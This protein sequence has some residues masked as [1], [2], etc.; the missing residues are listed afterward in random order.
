MSRILK[1]NPESNAAI[2]WAR[3]QNL[4]LRIL[5]GFEIALIAATFPL[6][7]GRHSFPV[8]PLITGISLP[9]II[10]HCVVCVLLAACAYTVAGFKTSRWDIIICGVA[11]TAAIVLVVLNQQRLQAWHWLF[12]L[13]LLT[14][15]FR[16]DNGL[17]LLQ[18][19]LASVY[20]CSAL[21]RLGPTAHQGMSAAILDQLLRMMHINPEVA[22]GQIGEILCH[23]FNIAE[24]AVGILLILP[25]SR[26]YG[27]LSAMLLHST[28]LL[29]LGPLG[30]RHHWGVL[31]WNIC[32][33]CLIP[34][35]FAGPRTGLKSAGP[36]SDWGFR[37]AT[38]CIWLFP[39]SG[40]VGIADNWP[41]WQLY[42]TRPESWTLQ[43]H[44]QDVPK[45]PESVRPHVTSPSPFEDSIVVKLDRWSLAETGSPISP[46]SRFQREV[47]RRVLTGFSDADE[48]QIH[49][50]EPERWRWWLRINRTLTTLEKLNAE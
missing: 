43:I 19:V 29:A 34:V 3:R 44:E 37:I 14:S 11:L 6:W 46:E 8:I 47:I 26:R 27:I 28:L 25:G 5:A 39:L 30:L 22:A 45:L 16:P 24:L 35:V 48:F 49:I 18:S 31:I 13:G 50:S 42:S 9:A 32:F 2:D 33:L 21:S 7:T 41:A 20:V 1:N 15:F 23:A 17:K 10:D 40:L 4:A 12:V 38:I 36:D